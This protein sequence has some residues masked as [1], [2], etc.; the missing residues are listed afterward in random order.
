M[1]LTSGLTLLGGIVV[2]RFAV[3]G[4]YRVAPAKFDPAQIGH[5]VRD[6]SFRLASIGYF[7]HMWELFAMWAWIA[8]FY[9]DALGSTRKAS[10]AAFT[11]MSAG[12]GGSIY[13]GMVSDRRSRPAA[14]GQALRASGALALVTGFLVDMPAPI[15]IAAGLVWGFWVVA[16][17]AQFSTIVTETSPSQY[18]GTALTMQLAAG[19]VLTV[20]TIF[21]VPVVRDAAG[22]GWA[23]AML[24]PGPFIGLWAMRALERD[25]VGAETA[26]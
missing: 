24:A 16:D 15:V 7:G 2:V 19:F 25:L 14:A 9:T 3:E 8:A 13:A 26:S 6:R 10:F 23:F 12:V 4:P 22:W 21:L 11:V 5:I 1:L 18:V 17:S 20:F